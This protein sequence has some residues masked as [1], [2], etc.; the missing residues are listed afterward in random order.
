M[1]F[2]G[3]IIDGA[4]H[5]IKQP[6]VIAN[7]VK[8]GDGFVE[9]DMK[10]KRQ[11][12]SQQNRYLHGLLIPEF[13][14]ALNSVGYDEVKDDVQAKE[15]L[16]AMFL[17]RHYE[18]SGSDLPQIPY[19]RDTS[20]LTKEEMGDLIEEVIKFAAEHMNYR[21]PYPNEQTEIEY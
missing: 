4:L 6:E 10:H 21:I 12:S 11:R 1:R 7:I 18:S 13:R 16:K 5:I 19:V 15:C 9:I 3:K 2:Y 17:T 20:T 14:K 8:F